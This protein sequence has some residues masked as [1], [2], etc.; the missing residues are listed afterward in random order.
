M[1]KHYVVYFVIF[2]A[3][4]LPPVGLCIVEHWQVCV[5]L[6]LCFLHQLELEYSLFLPFVVYTSQNKEREMIFLWMNP[7]QERNTSECLAVSKC[8]SSALPLAHVAYNHPNNMQ[9]DL[10]DMKLFCLW[11]TMTNTMAWPCETGCGGGAMKHD[12]ITLNKIPRCSRVDLRS[13]CC[14]YYDKMCWKD[15]K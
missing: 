11:E 13:F 1:W 8:A 3:F 9:Q 5:W 15:Q 12:S 10:A 4:F 2:T 7:K 6:W 14:K